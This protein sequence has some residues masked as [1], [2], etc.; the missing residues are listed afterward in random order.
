MKI[1]GIK[2][3]QTIEILEQLNNIPDGTEIIIDLE[4]VEKQI[5]E[6]K[7]HLT[8][9]ERL[10]KLNKLFGAWKNQP[11]LTEIFAEINQQCHAYQGRS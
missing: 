9:E 11:D 7:I 10:A 5:P 8:E 1:K 4:F 2:R 3:G 6:P